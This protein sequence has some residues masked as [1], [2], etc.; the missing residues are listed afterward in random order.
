MDEFGIP[1][2]CGDEELRPL[3]LVTVAS[4]AARIGIS[5]FEF[6]RYINKRPSGVPLGTLRSE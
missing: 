4:L 2:P 6:I 3:I 1:I 5:F